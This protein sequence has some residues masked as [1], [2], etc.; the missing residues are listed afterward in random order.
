MPK[1]KEPRNFWVGPRRNARQHRQVFQPV[2]YPTRKQA[3]HVQKVGGGKGARVKKTG[4]ISGWWVVA[5]IV[6]GVIVALTLAGC[7][8]GDVGL[9]KPSPG[10]VSAAASPTD[11]P[12][13]ALTLPP[14]AEKFVP[15][16]PL[17]GLVYLAHQV[18]AESIQRITLLRNPDGFWERTFVMAET[19]PRSASMIATR[20]WVG[21]L[22]CYLWYVRNGKVWL[23]AYD[24]STHGGGVACSI[25][26]LSLR[27]ALKSEG[28]KLED[29]D[30]TAGNDTVVMRLIWVPDGD[31][32]EK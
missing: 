24:E 9:G 6:I 17:H 2:N 7:K 25:N 32:Q 4:G 29:C 3:R 14:G 22:G 16:K 18:G 1:E 15:A 13:P 23:V 27:R 5:F 10:A 28:R 20:N 11:N 30:C 26:E 19:S 31:H 12:V 8:P 21:Q